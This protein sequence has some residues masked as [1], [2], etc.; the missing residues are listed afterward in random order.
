M[1][2][3]QSAKIVPIVWYD[4]NQKHA[5]RADF[6]T[7][8]VTREAHGRT[9]RCLWLWKTQHYWPPF[10]SIMLVMKEGSS[11]LLL[12]PHLLIKGKKRVHSD[13]ITFADMKSLKTGQKQ[14]QI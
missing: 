5:K 2:F 11:I 3:R 12:T 13:Q 7:P 1:A 9:H 6:G 14:S 4:F 10:L 8:L